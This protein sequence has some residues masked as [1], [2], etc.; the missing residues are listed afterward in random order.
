MNGE[1]GL[2]GQP[3]GR[4]LTLVDAML[5]GKASVE[6]GGIT[7]PARAPRTGDPLTNLRAT[8]DRC[9][10]DGQTGLANVVDGAADELGA[11]LGAC[12]T[13]LDR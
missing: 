2:D 13:I 9:R 6:F 10:E 1:L 3:R 8:A 4:N 5:G 11:I 7:L 12:N